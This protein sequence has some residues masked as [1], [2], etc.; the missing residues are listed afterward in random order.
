LTV[1]MRNVLIIGLFGL[2][3]C[4]GGTG[5]RSILPRVPQGAQAMSLSGRPL[6]VPPPA[7]ETLAQLEAAREAA[8]ADPGS[9]D[10]LV[11]LGRWTAYAGDYREAIRV[12]TRG[13]RKFPDDARFLRHRGHRYITIR[14]FERAV[15][16]LERAAAL[17]EG[18]PDA[19]EPDGRPNPRGIPVSTLHSNIFYH[20]GLAHYLNRDFD[21]ARAVYLKG[22]AAAPNDDMRVATTHWLYM[23]LR[24]LGLE[25]EAQ[26]ALEAIGPDME[27]IENTVYHRLCLFY[28]G[29]LA[30]GEVVGEGG[31][32]TT[33]D[34]AAYGLGRWHLA[35][36]DSPG[37]EAIFSRILEGP[38]WASF[39]Y[40]ATEADHARHYRP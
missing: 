10:A 39:G 25:E 12:F 9:A 16:D 6:A 40:I 34:A 29:A 15:R 24:R 3:T 37:A 31:E 5:D 32:A 35:N 23:T 13:V 19:I 30:E 11:W 28:K 26:A 33:I 36:G 20:L 21:A 18:R 4:S 1:R 7:A 14:E 27:V 2:A 17:V 22:L 8:S 38:G